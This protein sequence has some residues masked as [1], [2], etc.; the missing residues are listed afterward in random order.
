MPVITG[1]WE[2]VATPV[3]LSYPRPAS[4]IRTCVIVLPVLTT[5]LP[6]AVFIPEVGV[7]K[8]SV[9]AV[10]YQHHQKM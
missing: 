4:E 3:V 9:G 6:V 2:T 8:N 1:G 7:P 5:T 10:G